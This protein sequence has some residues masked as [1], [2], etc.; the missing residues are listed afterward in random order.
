MIDAS[1]GADYVRAKGIASNL[2]MQY[3]NVAINY[4]PSNVKELNVIKSIN[5]TSRHIE[6]HFEAKASI[7]ERVF[8]YVHRLVI[9]VYFKVIY[10]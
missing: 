2:T 8:H 3:G 4:K 10:G 7:I 9:L 1:F 6:R 5:T